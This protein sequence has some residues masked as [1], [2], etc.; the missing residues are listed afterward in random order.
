MGTGIVSILLHNLPYNV[1]GLY[2]VSVIIFI[3][4]VFLF[5]IFS[6]IF[7]ARYILYPGLW[8]KTINHPQISLSVGAYPMGLST[9]VVMI[10]LVCVPLWGD[11][12]VTLAWALWWA[13]SILS[14]MICLYIPFHLMHCQ[15][16]SLDQISGLWLL[17]MAS[18]IVASATGSVVSEVLHNQQHVLWTLVTCYFLWG[19][20]I[21]LS[22]MYLAM[23]LQ[24]LTL[25]QLPPRN[26]VV[27]ALIPVGPLGQGAFA[28]MQL[29][30]V[31]AANFSRLDVLAHSKTHSGYILYVGGWLIGLVMWAYGLTWLFLALATICR[32][33]FPF[34]MGWWSFIF[35]LGVW[36]NA[37]ITFGKEMPSAFFNILGTVFTGVVTLLWLIVAGRTIWGLYRRQLFTAPDFD[38]WRMAR[39]KARAEPI[40]LDL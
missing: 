25:H 29:G 26:L 40:A 27:S 16:A 33:R 32:G 38:A 15:K 20:S 6:C 12:V 34:N 8:T 3:I 19:S 4:N 28:I 35:P 37:T 7:L 10:V 9:I 36:T 17:P 22:M 31:A 13:D 24:R 11:W 21:P 39:S 30:R 18:A 23:Y 1:K 2:W 5:V 14:V